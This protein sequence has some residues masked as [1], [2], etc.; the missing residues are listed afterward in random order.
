MVVLNLN[1]SMKYNNTIETFYGKNLLFTVRIIA[2]LNQFMKD[3]II[4]KIYKF[5]FSPIL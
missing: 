5:P 1:F 4:K 2:K 3:R